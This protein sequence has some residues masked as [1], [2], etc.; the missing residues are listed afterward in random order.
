MRALA[1]ASLLALSL[2]VSSVPAAA[3][4]DPPGPSPLMRAVTLISDDI[5]TTSARLQD[6]LDA[7]AMME[8]QWIVE[9]GIETLDAMT[10]PRCERVR[11]AA[12]RMTLQMYGDYLRSVVM[13]NPR[14]AQGLRFAFILNRTYASNLQVSC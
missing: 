12:Y 4:V 5:I 1:V 10:V 2:I 11:W 13:R 6:P 9:Q 14:L 3:W 8:L 7:N